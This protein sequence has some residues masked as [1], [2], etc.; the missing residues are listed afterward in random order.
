MRRSSTAEQVAPQRDDGSSSPPELAAATNAPDAWPC[1][2][3]LHARRGVLLLGPDFRPRWANPAAHAL[4]GLGATAG[5]GPALE[6]RWREL[7]A[8]IE[9]RLR[10]WA[11]ERDWPREG[12][13]LELDAPRGGA[14]RLR[15]EVHRGDGERG[16][17]LVLADPGLEEAEARELELAS[18]MRSLIRLQRSI[19]H[20]LRS[21][22]NAMTLN[23]ELLRLGFEEREEGETDLRS[24]EGRLEGHVDTLDR[25]LGRLNRSLQTAFARLE[26]TDAG[27]GSFDV[28]RLVREILATVRPQAK[29]Q[30]VRIE[31]RVPD[32]PVIVVA[33]RRQLDQVFLNL[34]LNALDAMPR[35]GGLCIELV[36]EAEGVLLR[37]SD[38]GPG[39]PPE[40]TERLFECHAPTAAGRAGIGLFVARTLAREHGGDV[41]LVRTSP[42]GSAFEMRLPRSQSEPSR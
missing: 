31:A 39:V 37:V 15:C 36:S 13:A 33:R 3:A 8:S 17:L 14:T 1:A 7:R 38:E 10:E 42:A 24:I 40:L 28:R 41:R 29:S 12:R 4:L 27:P 19:A 34:V 25:D 9:P 35:G 21:P 6:A 20:Q 32:R 16:W 2:I 5:A 22:L 18:R 30:Q 11:R 26:G 23:L